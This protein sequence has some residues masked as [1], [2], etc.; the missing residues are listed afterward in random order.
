M[1][2]YVSIASAVVAFK[3]Q[4]MPTKTKRGGGAR[5]LWR[6]DSESHF[7][8]K[9]LRPMTMYSPHPPFFLGVRGGSV[10]HPSGVF[11]IFFVTLPQKCGGDGEEGSVVRTVE[12]EVKPT[13]MLERGRGDQ[14][15][16]SGSLD[17]LVHAFRGTKR[18][19][20]ARFRSGKYDI[21]TIPVGR[22]VQTQHGGLHEPFSF[23]VGQKKNVFLL[24]DSPPEHKG[25]QFA[26]S[27][28]SLFLAS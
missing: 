8:F 17:L 20:S 1:S 3:T 25:P 14:D 13:V 6:K 5:G 10:G 21:E 11:F 16:V 22:V 23:D 19:R 7:Q 28:L 4:W 15:E 9:A 2:F 27:F 12:P 24:G 18:F 26:A